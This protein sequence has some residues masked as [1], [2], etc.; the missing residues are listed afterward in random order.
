MAIATAMFRV[1]NSAASVKRSFGPAVISI[2]ISQ[3]AP[4]DISTNTAAGRGCC[5]QLAQEGA[6]ASRMMSR[7]TIATP[8]NASRCSVVAGSVRQSPARRL[9]HIPTASGRPSTM[10]SCPKSE[11]NR[12]GE[13]E[14][15]AGSPLERLADER[16]RQ[17]GQQAGKAGQ[18]D[19]QRRRRPGQIAIGVGDTAN[20]TGCDEQHA[21]G[22]VGR[23]FEHRG[24][25]QRNRRQ[26]EQR[27]DQPRQH[28]GTVPAYAGEIICGQVQAHRDEQREIERRHHHVDERLHHRLRPGYPPSG[29]IVN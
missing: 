25:E 22:D 29:V 23:R 15:L 6:G 11:R 24:E 13:I 19:R 17:A 1:P 14:G 28:E 2:E 16:N 18:R 12:G 7:K 20:R 8:L 26:D 10:T 5:R 9:T 3:P 27:G 4:I 21:R